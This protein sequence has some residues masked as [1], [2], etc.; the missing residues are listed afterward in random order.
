M[1]FVVI[2]IMDWTG[3][4]MKRSVYWNSHVLHFPTFDEIFWRKIHS[5]VGKKK[6]GVVQRTRVVL[7]CRE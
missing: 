7:E 4:L 3:I 6:V 1:E 5:T 2:I